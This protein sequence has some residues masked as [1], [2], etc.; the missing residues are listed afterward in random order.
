MTAED[1]NAESVE[2]EATETPETADSEAVEDSPESEI[3]ALKAFTP[4]KK[5]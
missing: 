1:Q 3:E 5:S 4:F 2:E